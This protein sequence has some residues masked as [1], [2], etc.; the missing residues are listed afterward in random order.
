MPISRFVKKSEAKDE[1]SFPI[2]FREVSLLQRVYSFQGEACCTYV[3]DYMK[4]VTMVNW[5]RCWTRR[6]CESYTEL[7]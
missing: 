3:W 7:F 6:P 1:T 2:T 5:T 4:P